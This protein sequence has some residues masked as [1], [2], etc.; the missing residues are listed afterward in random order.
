MLTI[1]YNLLTLIKFGRLIGMDTTT[2]LSLSRW[3]T[4]IDVDDEDIDNY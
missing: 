3:Y 1:T 4:L 2:P